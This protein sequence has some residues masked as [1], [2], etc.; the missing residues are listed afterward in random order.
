MYKQQCIGA[1]GPLMPMVAILSCALI[2]YSTAYTLV[3]TQGWPEWTFIWL[4][5][6]ILAVAA[7]TWRYTR[8]GM[9]YMWF[10]GELVVRRSD[11][12]KDYRLVIAQDCIDGLHDRNA[13]VGYCPWGSLAE[14]CCATLRGRFWDCCTL[15]YHDGYGRALKL[16]FQPTAELRRILIQVIGTETEASEKA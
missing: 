7:L 1:R 16:R 4:V 2:L 15:Y 13:T 12:V 14:N 6:V 10:S 5:V 8:V 9:E 3:R 11:R